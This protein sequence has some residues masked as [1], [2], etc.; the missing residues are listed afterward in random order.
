MPRETLGYELALFVADRELR[1]GR[2][3]RVPD[4]L[5]EAYALGDAELSNRFDVEF[6]HGLNLGCPDS[7][8]DVSIRRG[9]GLVALYVDE[10]T[11]SEVE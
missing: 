11:G 5:D 7:E 4:L 3:Q 1:R 2:L 6:D 8:S 10:S 9:R